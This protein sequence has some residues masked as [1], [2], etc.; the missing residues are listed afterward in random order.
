MTDNIA[1][2]SISGEVKHPGE[3][4]VSPYVTLN[5][6]YVL[7]GGFTERADQRAIFLSRESVKE[8]ERIAFDDARKLLASNIY[9][10]Q[11][12]QTSEGNLEVSLLA[13][14]NDPVFQNFP[15]RVSGDLSFNSKISSNLT[16][17]ESDNIVVPPI[18]NFIIVSGEVQSPASIVFE[19]NF[20][21]ND[22]LEAAGGLTRF[23]NKSKI[24]VIK[25]N[26]TSVPYNRFGSNYVLQ[27]GD[28]IQVPKNLGNVEL[29]P[30]IAVVS[31]VMANLAL[32]AASLNAIN[33]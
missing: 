27:P 7:A 17:E 22:Y 11:A 1:T 12:N 3:Y 20:T 23:A 29:I 24:Y 33:N 6:L 26:G 16:L 5:D 21:I 9:E 2:V 10:T 14:L 32:S 30:I 13:L 19:E 15:G 4:D 31:Q 28:L 8:K 25:A 18:R